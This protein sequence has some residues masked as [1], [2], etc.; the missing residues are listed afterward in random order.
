[1]W[2][3][4]SQAISSLPGGE[5]NDLRRADRAGK[6]PKVRV[7]RVIPAI[8]AKHLPVGVVSQNRRLPRDAHVTLWLRAMDKPP[9]RGARECPGP[10]A[11][12]RLD[13]QTKPKSGRRP[14]D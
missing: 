6:Q 7:P 14:K 12:A 3:K 4:P 9:H 11:A 10:F 2:G 8:A 13:S 5:E 1:M